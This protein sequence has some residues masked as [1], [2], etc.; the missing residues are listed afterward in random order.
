[1]GHAEESR[2]KDNFLPEHKPWLV[3]LA[4]GD[5]V[6]EGES[7]C[8]GVLAEEDV[9]VNNED[10]LLRC[11][12]ASPPLS[13]GVLLAFEFVAELSSEMGEEQ[14]VSM[15]DSWG[16][17]CCCCCCC[18]SPKMPPVGSKSSFSGDVQVQGQV[19]VQVPLPPLLLK[20]DV[21]VAEDEELV[22]ATESTLPGALMVLE[23]AAEEEVDSPPAPPF[24]C[25]I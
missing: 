8:C 1:M 7:G 20:V 14:F 19:H 5:E 13:L 21:E 11:L 25:W 6:S 12:T 18:G 9:V 24:C 16:I 23:V 15:R 4:E 17:C 10:A 22:E 2:T 3:E